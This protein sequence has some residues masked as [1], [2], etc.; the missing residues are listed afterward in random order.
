LLSII[1]DMP[2]VGMRVFD[3]H[4]EARRND[5]PGASSLLFSAE[6]HD[7]LRDR[8]KFF[9][10]RVKSAPNRWRSCPHEIPAKWA[11]R[12]GRHLDWAI[13]RGFLVGGD[14]LF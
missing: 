11:D 14:S 12:S 4:K 2:E 7:L 3:V 10:S 13:W 1:L 6:V 9:S 8:A 5:E